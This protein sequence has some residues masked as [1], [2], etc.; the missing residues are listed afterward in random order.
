MY[1]IEKYKAEKI[2]KDTM[3]KSI[4]KKFSLTEGY[5][6]RQTGQTHRI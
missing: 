5:L 2:Y 1:E 3:V 6:E 4:F